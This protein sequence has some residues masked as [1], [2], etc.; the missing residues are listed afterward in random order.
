MSLSTSP[1]LWWLAVVATF[2]SLLWAPH[3]LQLVANAGLVPTVMD[4]SGVN[5]PEAEW[6]QR[7]KRAHQN[8]VEN[9]VVFATFA[10]LIAMTGLGDGLTATAAMV[11]F[12]ARAGHF[13]VYIAGLPV[14]RTLFFATGV[15]CQ[16]IMA[17]RLFGI[18]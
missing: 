8:A 2:T 10:I 12:Y 14:F 9:L 1:E 11:Y 16:L 15:I 3:I 6:A 17:A 13:V 4:P 5:R 7:G 18:V